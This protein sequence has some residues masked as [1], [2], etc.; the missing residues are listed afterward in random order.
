MKAFVR[1]TV[2]GFV[3]IAALYAMLEIAVGIGFYRLVPLDNDPL[4]NSVAVTILP[5]SSAA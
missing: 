5:D 1:M 2:R 3:G 4:T